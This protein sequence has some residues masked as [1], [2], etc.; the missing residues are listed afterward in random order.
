MWMGIHTQ[1]CLAEVSNAK[2]HIVEMD[3]QDCGYQRRKFVGKPALGKVANHLLGFATKVI[4]D[5]KAFGL[6]MAAVG[7]GYF[8]E[9]LDWAGRV[10]RRKYKLQ[11]GE[12]SDNQS[13]DD[14]DS[15]N[16]E[17]K[18]PPGR[19]RGGFDDD[20]GEGCVIC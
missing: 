17:M 15:G 13:G 10:A 3:E 5:R 12:E 1:Q 18:P 20:D 2:Q 9:R 14:C 19:R 11:A 7:R 6:L 4:G 8:N 16:E